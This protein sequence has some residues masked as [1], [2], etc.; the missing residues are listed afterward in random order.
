MVYMFEICGTKLR[1]SKLL[2]SRTNMASNKEENITIN[3][4]WLNNKACILLH[5]QYRIFFHNVIVVFIF[6]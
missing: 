5:V 6:I 1:G 2:H 4:K 3:R